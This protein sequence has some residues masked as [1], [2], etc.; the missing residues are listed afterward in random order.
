MK[1]EVGKYFAPQ[2]PFLITSEMLI[3]NGFLFKSPACYSGKIIKVLPSNEIIY[4]ILGEY[5]DRIY[6]DDFNE[7]YIYAGFTKYR[8]PSFQ[9]KYKLLNGESYF[10]SN[11]LKYNKIWNLI[12]FNGYNKIKAI[13]KLLSLI[14]KFKY[15][16]V[17]VEN[18]N[19]ITNL[20]DDIFSNIYSWLTPDQ[21]LKYRC[22][23]CWDTS[24]VSKIILEKLNIECHEIYCEMD[25]NQ[26]YPTHTFVIIKLD[27]KFHI[28]EVSWK[29]YISIS[30]GFYSI[31]ECCFEMSKRMYNQY[32]K[33]KNISFYEEINYPEYGCSCIEY[34]DFIK[35]NNHCILIDSYITK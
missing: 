10:V 24:H 34:M 12:K 13:K 9:I 1:I 30:D 17:D 26:D 21:V 15:G 35:K 28:F 3:K 25:M 23:V 16:V 6:Y 27:N 7:K 4:E 19:I 14:G 8:C 2:K 11:E 18:D 33:S 22:G 31:N 5:Q 32:P 20:N 29:S